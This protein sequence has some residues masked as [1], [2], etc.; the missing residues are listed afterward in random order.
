M[1]KITLIELKKVLTENGYSYK[2]MILDGKSFLIIS[3]KSIEVAYEG[4]HCSDE[5]TEDCLECEEEEGDHCADEDCDGN[6]TEKE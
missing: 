2:E 5:D 3:D 4:D 6:C 1:A